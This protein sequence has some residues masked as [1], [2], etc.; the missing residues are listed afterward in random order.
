[1][2]K[3]TACLLAAVLSV[4]MGIQ[5]VFAAVSTNAQSWAK[6]FVEKAY[7]NG[8]AS[9]E[10]LQKATSP[11]T[12]KEFCH[13]AVALYE[14]I[15]GK[16]AVPSGES[17]FTDCNDLDVL[18]ASDLKIIS[19]MGDGTFHPDDPLTREQLCIILSRLL[20]ACGITLEG[21]GSGRT[22]T[23]ISGLSETS[24]SYIHKISDAGFM[25]GYTDGTFLPLNSLKVEEAMIVLVNVMEYALSLNDAESEKSEEAAQP[26][27]DAAEIV[28]PEETV[29]QE[30]EKSQSEAV[31][32][33]D[34]PAVEEKAV[35]ASTVSVNGKTVFVGMT[36]ENLKKIW[37]EPTDIHETVYGLER[38]VYANEPNVCLLATM[39]NNSVITFFVLADGIEWNG[40]AV[41]K[42]PSQINAEIRVSA[43]THSGIYEDENVLVSFPMDYTGNICGI[44]VTELEFSQEDRL[45][46]GT[47]L[48]LREDLAQE[49]FAVINTLRVLEEEEPLIWE[50]ALASSSLDHSMDMVKQNY[51]DY[52]SLDGTTP[53]ARIQK[54]AISFHTASEVIAS[55]RGDVPELFTE[56]IKNTG[57]YNIITDATMTHAGV[58]IASSTKTLYMT[59]DMCG[60][61]D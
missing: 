52:N 37:G 35:G 5:P 47:N 19:G 7:E 48:S 46:S 49:M 59:M 42:L 61:E 6:A 54:K 8:L 53:F 41:T 27:E 36:A 15:T 31:S 56:L 21:T 17:T 55:A 30:E 44:N 33:A 14:L 22:F 51:F 12:R 34:Q 60:F 3:L 39:E 58:G 26:E 16:E 57:R 40:T 24:Q 38:Y 20:D 18:A 11:I 23:D 28:Q 9:E 45:A 32:E 4:C 29:Q 50:S 2:K 1:M 25:S 10:L 13:S 43:F